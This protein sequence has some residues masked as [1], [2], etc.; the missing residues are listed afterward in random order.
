[1]PSNANLAADP[2]AP[3]SV[4]GSELLEC[5]LPQQRRG[6]ALYLALGGLVGAIAG[7]L[8][9]VAT[10]MHADLNPVAYLL[11][12]TG[13]PVGGLAYRVR[14]SRWPVDPS[15]RSRQ[16]RASAATLLLPTAIGVLTG[17]RAQGLGM[18]IV[19]ALIAL[20]LVLGIFV[21]GRR[22]CRRYALTGFRARQDPNMLAT[23]RIH[24]DRDYFETQYDDWLA[25]RARWRKYEVWFALALTLFGVT[26]AVAFRNQWVGGAV[27]TCL[28]VYELA[29]AVTHRR[30]WVNAR[31]SSVRDGKLVD[32]KFSGNVMTTTSPNGTATMKL[33]AFSGFTPAANGF[34]LVPDTGVSIYIPRA[35]VTPPTAYETVIDLLNSVVKK[36]SENEPIG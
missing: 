8:I 31:L 14:S 32:V 20:S 5:E 27:F 25:Y 16:L 12:L 7:T 34:F 3:P 15:V 30:R 11:I 36:P 26:L 24:F 21:S 18:T 17:M 22:R 13:V 6:P 2:Y 9:I 19:G 35:A 29:M 28:G 33:S 1:M 23:A 10:P 4:P